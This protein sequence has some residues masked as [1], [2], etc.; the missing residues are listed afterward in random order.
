MVGVSMPNGEFNGVPEVRREEAGAVTPAVL[1]LRAAGKASPD[2]WSGDAAFGV[3][4]LYG[5]SG[6]GLE[7]WK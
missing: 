3:K 6:V 1:I 5:L 4:R 7:L 2:F